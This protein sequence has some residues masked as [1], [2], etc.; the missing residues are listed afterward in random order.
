MK[1]DKGNQR[2]D[3]A[4]IDNDVAIAPADVCNHGVTGIMM[5]TNTGTSMGMGTMTGT[6]VGEVAGRA[7]E[8]ADRGDSV[9]CGDCINLGSFLVELR[10]ETPDEDRE[11]VS[12]STL[13]DDDGDFR[14]FDHDSDDRFFDDEWDQVFDRDL[15]RR[16][17]EGKENELEGNHG[18]ERCVQRRDL[19]QLRQRQHQHGDDDAWVQLLN[20]P[21]AMTSGGGL[22]PVGGVRRVS[23]CYFSI[24][25]NLS[26]GGFGSVGCGGG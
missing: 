12:C 7:G 5:G 1:I 15:H 22:G 16:G 18:R 13:D 21:S 6:V 19:H 4:L 2:M 10:L 8:Q 3:Q 9:D 20:L 26:E 17:G 11:G 25:S 23:S 14:L 24:A